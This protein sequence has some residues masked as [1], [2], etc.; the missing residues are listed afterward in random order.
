MTIALLGCSFNKPD[1][2]VLTAYDLASK[3]EYEN[4]YY[5]IVNLNDLSRVNRPFA[6]TYVGTIDAYHLFREW[7]KIKVKDGEVFFFAL[8]KKL[9][10]VHDEATPTNEH[11]YYENI[12]KQYRHVSL[13]NGKCFVPPR[14]TP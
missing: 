6:I 5:Y 2:D 4:R 13:E 14:K 3:I 7:S 9:C 11:N 10:A 12:F 8:P 1:K